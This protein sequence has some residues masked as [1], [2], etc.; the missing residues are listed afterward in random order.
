MSQNIIVSLINILSDL[1]S[2]FELFLLNFTPGFNYFMGALF[3]ISLIAL[4]F[5]VIIRSS[6]FVEVG[7]K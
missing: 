5:W 7:T 4:M 3:M 6:S 1:L 2:E